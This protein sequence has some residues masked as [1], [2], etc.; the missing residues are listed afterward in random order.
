MDD[1]LAYVD[2]WVA[3]R[4]EVRDIPGIVLGVRSDQETVFS[5]AF[6]FAKL[7]RRV[8]MTPRHIFRIASH[9][10]TCTATAIMQLVERGRLRLDDP[11]AAYIPRLGGG[12]ADVTLRQV[13]NH[14]AGIVRDGSN[15]DYWQLERPFPDA[16]ELRHLTEDGGAVLAANETFK[17]SN[18][19]YSLLGLVIEAASGSSYQAYVKE[20]IIDALG[21][22]DTGV[23]TDAQA[24]RRMVTG[25]TAAR[26]GIPRRAL[27]DVVTHAMAPAT[28]F[29]STADDLCRYAAAHLLGSGKL[30]SDATIVKIIDFALKLGRSANRSAW[31]REWFTGRLVNQGG[32]TDVVG[33]GDALVALHPDEDDPV[34]R[35]TELR[36]VDEHTL[37]VRATN[38][39]GAPGET[40]RYERD[41][42]HKVT[43]IVAAGLSAYL[44]DLYTARLHD[45]P[46]SRGS[47]YKTHKRRRPA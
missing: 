25:Y 6:G 19:G 30:L 2:A 43:R 35:V 22:Q 5:K 36:A 34:R 7:E 39:Y 14:A 47:A 42:A 45:A 16:D 21:L 28:G 46:A 18:V 11:L 38:G 32:V 3:Y 29:Y 27:A 24:Q 31:P 20:H 17:Y 4:R 33:F 41:A 15:A 26:L 13:L 1:A 44:L 40:I 10:K 37:Q 12:L 23:D 8:P 9:S